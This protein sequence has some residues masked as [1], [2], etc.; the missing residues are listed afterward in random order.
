MG[1]VISFR[2]TRE[3]LEILDFTMRFHRL[4]TRSEAIRHL[5]HAGKPTRANLA[6]LLA[7]RLG[8]RPAKRSLSA[9]DI[10]R[11]LARAAYPEPRKPRT[12]GKNRPAKARR[13]RS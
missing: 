8:D 11:E 10:D 1:D 4:N 12:A 3:D 6:P 7:F 9:R 13:R 5:L 2:P